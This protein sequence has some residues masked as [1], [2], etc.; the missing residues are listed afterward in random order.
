M[1]EF[2]ALAQ[3]ANAVLVAN[4]S[5]DGS[6][7]ESREAGLARVWTL[8]WRGLYVLVPFAVLSPIVSFVNSHYALTWRL[9]LVESYLDRWHATDPSDEALEGAS[10]R[11]H[12]DTQ[13]FA[14]S[15]EGGVLQSFSA[16]L[17]LI[18]FSPRL[19]S[20]GAKLR[21][22]LFVRAWYLGSLGSADDVPA[23]WLLHMCI[24][25]AA[26]GFSVA[27]LVTR[28]LVAIEVHNQ[29]VEAALRKRLVAA[30]GP[31]GGGASSSAK[32]E[33]HEARKLSAYVDLLRSLRHLT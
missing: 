11:V 15:L 5:S 7:I 3:E 4:A 24:V 8:L 6:G 30:E 23:A 12:E 26:V 2:Y 20:L 16:I 22:P 10:Q 28:H 9:C 31:M 1:G 17:T 29:Q 13:R 19:I 18:V 32:H 14:R 25:V 33:A 21:P 27:V